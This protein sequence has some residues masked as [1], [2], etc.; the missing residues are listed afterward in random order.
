[1]S[2]GYFGS[3]GVQRRF[4]AGIRKKWLSNLVTLDAIKELRR[5]SGAGIADV[6]AALTLAGGD[7]EHAMEVL[8]AKGAESLSNKAGRVTEQGLVACFNP[9]ARSGIRNN[10]FTEVAAGDQ[11]SR[12]ACIAELRCETDFVARNE[13]F[14]ALLREIVH[15]VS[16]QDAGER[17]YASEGFA[18][19]YI[20]ETAAALGENIQLGTVHTMR[21]TN[22]SHHVASYVHNAVESDMGQIGVLVS[23]SGPQREST[24]QLSRHVAMHI[25]AMSPKYIRNEE[26]IDDCVVP[27]DMILESQV[28]VVDDHGRTVGD[29]LKQNDMSILSF[30]RVAVAGR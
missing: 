15:R 6:K 28:F 7:M 16:L 10:E 22:E 5:I 4:L 30:H 19:E 18:S 27:E 29:V 11:G 12:V 13:R 23:L 24:K 8:R 9:Y 2:A 25:A 17:A 20:A 14:R 3:V 1:M 26:A 21:I